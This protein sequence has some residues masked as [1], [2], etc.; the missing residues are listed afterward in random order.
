VIARNTDQLVEIRDAIGNALVW[1]GLLALLTGVAAG[2]MLS[3]KQLRR[4][5][6]TQQVIEKIVNGNLNE[7]LPI[8][9]RD[10]LDMLAHLVNHMLDR[11]ARLMAEVKG[12]CDGVAHDLR[13]PLGHVLKTLTQARTHARTR[14]DAHMAGLL[15][16]A[17]AET[18]A[19]LNR[20]RAM[21]RISEIESMRRRGGFEEFALPP[22]LAD[23]EDLYRPLAEE[24]GLAFS[25]DADPGSLESIR[26]DRALLFEALSNLLDN[27]IKFTNDGAIR[28][29]L[30]GGKGGPQ[31]DVID[32][33]PGIAA[34]DRS[35]V[36]QR[37][38]RTESSRHIAGSGLGLSI[39]SA[40]AALHDFGLSIDEASP[41]T[42]VRLACW[43]QTLA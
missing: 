41:G 8:G 9:G 30:V 25:F 21:L 31:I 34:A 38:Y 36:L 5:H 4:I 24:K 13:T 22:L 16:Y 26:G 42:H 40:V 35:A 3:V 23:L 18:E 19:L 27:A 28:L 7:R 15:E 10:E 14:G 1:G 12:A 6:E 33:G 29:R 17:E 2:L 11:I 32:S 39:V 43:P 37:F 20:F